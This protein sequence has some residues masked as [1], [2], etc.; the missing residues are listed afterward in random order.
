[1][2]QLQSLRR[3]PLRPFVWIFFATTLV[4]GLWVAKDYGISWD[5]KAMFVLGEKAFEYVVFGKP[6][7]T[8][9]GIRFH[10]SFLEFL[11]TASQ[12]LMQLRYARHVFIFRHAVGFFIYWGGMLA[13]YALALKHFKHRGWALLAALI[14]FL[15]PRQF[16]HAF[17]N[18][19][20]IP[21]MVLFTICMLTLL[22]CIDRKTLRSAFLHGVTS[23]MVVALRVGGLFA[24]IY[25][26]LFFFLEILR[27][28]LLGK[29]IPWK[30][31]ALLLTVCGRLCVCG[32]IL[33]AVVVGEATPQFLRGS[34]Q[35]D[36]EPEQSWWSVFWKGYQHY[37]MALDSRAYRHQNAADVCAALF[38]RVVVFCAGDFPSSSSDSFRKPQSLALL[39]LVCDTH[40]YR[41]RSPSGSLR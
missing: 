16:G 13:I 25:T 2:I 24:P 7:T 11:L 20:D 40:F 18:T 30:R 34:A 36:D 14:Y 32:C 26:A 33:L 1:M 35:Y 15:S 17:V 21:S 39:L 38:Y 19:R 28:V 29:T 4:L 12:Q 5:E 27:E 37:S 8:H 31:Y 23:G 10:G 9:I 22:P 3:I 6:Y 41:H